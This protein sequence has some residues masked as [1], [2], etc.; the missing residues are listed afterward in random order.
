MLKKRLIA[1]FIALI[2]LAMAWTAG[3]QLASTAAPSA[4]KTLP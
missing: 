3:V 1:T 4:H 2:A